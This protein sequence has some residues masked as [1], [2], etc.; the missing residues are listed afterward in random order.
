MTPDAKNLL[1]VVATAFVTAAAS[2]LGLSKP[3]VDRVE[4]TSQAR[5]VVSC[6]NARANRALARDIADGLLDPLPVPDDAVPALRAYVELT[7]AERAR[8]REVIAERTRQPV[9]CLQ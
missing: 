3:A 8:Q 5:H 2:Y 6:A 9:E 4:D 7:N 1:M